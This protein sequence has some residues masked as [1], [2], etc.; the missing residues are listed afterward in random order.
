MQTSFQK[1][2]SELNQKLLDEMEQSLENVWRAKLEK[3][4][5]LVDMKLNES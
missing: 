5:P 3:L 2:Y 4:L 1:A